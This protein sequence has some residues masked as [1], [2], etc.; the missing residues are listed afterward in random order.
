MVDPTRIQKSGRLFLISS[1]VLEVAVF[2]ISPPR[3]KS[4]TTRRCARQGPLF[5]RVGGR[6]HR[7]R[8]RRRR[9]RLFRRSS[10]WRSVT[11]DHRTRKSFETNWT[12]RV[13]SGFAHFLIESCG[14]NVTYWSA[15]EEFTN[16]EWGITPLV[17]KFR[18]L[19]DETGPKEEW[20]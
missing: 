3:S 2:L 4:S 17:K 11:R 15:F 18:I 12:V 19:F 9:D 6:R 16:N 13:R 10:A 14:I 5:R 20:A 1:F 8:R 7:R